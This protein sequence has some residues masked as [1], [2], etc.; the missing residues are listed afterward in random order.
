MKKLIMTIAIVLGIGMACYAENGG[1]FGRG[2]TA[3]ETNTAFGGSR[4]GGTPLFPHH[5]ELT[6]QPAVPLGGGMAVLLGLGTIYA[7]A[8]R[9]EED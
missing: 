7:V 1:L 4:L 8:K 3:P 2:E 5:N 9:R 6:N